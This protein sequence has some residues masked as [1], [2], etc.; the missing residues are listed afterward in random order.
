MNAGRDVEELISVWLNEE[1]TER[2][3]DR[4]LDLAGRTID[5]TKQRR[6]GVAW[7]EPTLTSTARLLAA[8]AVLIVSVAGA[9]LIGRATAGIGVPPASPSPTMSP[10][11]AA[12]P[13]SSVS[14][15]AMASYRAARDAYCTPANA[16]LITLNQQGDKLDPTKSAADRAAMI[17]VLDQIV[18]LGADEVQHLAAIPAPPEIAAEHAADVEH[19]RDS[20]AILNEALLL[21]R[22]GKVTEANTVA[23]A[24]GPLSSLEEQ[25][26]TKYGF[27]GC[28]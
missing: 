10:S 20:R 3:P 1:A 6:L 24:T 25:F 9:A 14:A 15:V 19:H 16:H 4:V 13:S 28:P 11:A 8:A 17:S 2:A 21:L 23:N 12:S 27:A 18:A 26:E 22:A 7:K 5:R